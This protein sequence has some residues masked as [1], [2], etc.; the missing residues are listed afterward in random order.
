MLVARAEEFA[1][2]VHKSSTISHLIEV[3][4][5]VKELGITQDEVLLA[6]AW[7]HLTLKETEV[8][9]STIKTQFGKEVADIV[10]GIPYFNENDIFGDDERS[11]LIML[12]SKVVVTEN[13]IDNDPNSY[14]IYKKQFIPLREFL[15][16]EKSISYPIIYLWY[17]LENLYRKE[18]DRLSVEE[19][20]NI[21]K[22]IYSTNLDEMEYVWEKTYSLD[23]HSPWVTGDWD[24]KEGEY[25]DE[26]YQ[27]VEE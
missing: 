26:K 7:L 2:L 4:L 5:T 11:L 1:R 20:E 16:D 9:Y 22:D 27:I 15:Y 25:Y 17:Y 3:V 14:E 21:A 23:F 24:E 10:Y 8:T 19:I 13:A 6:S 12:V 18:E